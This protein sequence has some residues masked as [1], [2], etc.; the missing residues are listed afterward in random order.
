MATKAGEQSDTGTISGYSR[1][2]AQGLS[3]LL[4]DTYTLYLKTHNYHWNVTGPNFASLHLLFEQQYSEL[5]LAV[6]A[7]AERIRALGAP[8]PGS[9][10]QFAGLARV[11]DEAELPDSMEMVGR[12]LGDHQALLETAREAL[13][14]AEEHHDQPSA[15]LVSERMQVHQKAAWMLRATLG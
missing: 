14:T 4:A 2:V 7:L 13:A 6:D 12:L 1:V 11:A 8:A 10:K 9:Y 3:R 5:A 15:D